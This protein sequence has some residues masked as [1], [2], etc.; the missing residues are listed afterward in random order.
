MESY[1]T[2]GDALD[3]GVN[4]AA[5]GPIFDVKVAYCYPVHLGK[6][7]IGCKSREAPNSCVGQCVLYADGIRLGP[8]YHLYEE[9]VLYTCRC[10]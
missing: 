7:L 4:L 2:K 9:G 1:Y 5:A 3:A 6:Q 8:D 10:E